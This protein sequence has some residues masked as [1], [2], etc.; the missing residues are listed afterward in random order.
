MVGNAWQPWVVPTDRLVL[1][2]CE[3][4]QRVQVFQDGSQ[5][6]HVVRDG[7]ICHPNCSTEDVMCVLASYLQTERY[8]RKLRA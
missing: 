4:P 5:A 1:D 7:F 3:G 8:L 2:T 6:Y